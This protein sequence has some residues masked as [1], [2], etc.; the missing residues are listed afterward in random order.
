MMEREVR[1]TPARD[2]S[3]ELGWE[4]SSGSEVDPKDATDPFRMDLSELEVPRGKRAP[5]LKNLR[6]PSW[7]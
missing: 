6:N 3:G 1:R 2:H 5:N 4:A 7:G